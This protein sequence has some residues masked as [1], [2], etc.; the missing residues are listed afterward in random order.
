MKFKLNKIPFKR[1]FI[2]LNVAKLV[3][4][5]CIINKFYILCNLLVEITFNTIAIMKLKTKKPEK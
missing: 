2:N 3:N 1:Q 4:N 5:T